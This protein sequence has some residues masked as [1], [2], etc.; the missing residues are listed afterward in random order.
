M[1]GTTLPPNTVAPLQSSCV[2]CFK[3]SPAYRCPGCL[4]RYC[5]VACFNTHKS[6]SGCRGMRDVKD[7]VLRYISR[8]ELMGR[9]GYSSSANMAENQEKTRD[10]QLLRDRDYNFLSL[11]ERRIG[12]QRNI[13]QDA[14]RRGTRRTRGRGGRHGGRGGRG[15]ISR[16]HS[17]VVGQTRK[18][19]E[20]GRSGDDSDGAS[21]N[22][23]NNECE[24][25]KASS[26]DVVDSKPHAHTLDLDTEH[27]DDDEPPEE[28]SSNVATA[29]T[30]DF[31]ALR[32]HNAEHEG[33][34]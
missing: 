17:R 23:S 32:E 19:R 31:S 30:E 8:T 1:D 33:Y 24:D 9:Q 10:M 18:S 25:S 27:S 16:A 21:P 15:N 7:A 4:V 22:N 3:E 28:A 34:R 11:L 12:V 26:V 2:T 14:L 13:A 20:D 6:R 5:S 29:I